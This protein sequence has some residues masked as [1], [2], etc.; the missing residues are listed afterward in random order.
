MFWALMQQSAAV[1]ERLHNTGRCCEFSS[2]VCPQT[3]WLAAFVELEHCEHLLQ[4]C[5]IV[6]AMMP[7]TEACLLMSRDANCEQSTPQ[8]MSSRVE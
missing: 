6:T 2:R 5:Q 1:Q 7:F 4:L 8:Q 3:A